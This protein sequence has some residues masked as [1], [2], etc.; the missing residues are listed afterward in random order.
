[1]SDAEAKF[2]ANVRRVRLEKGMT[3]DQVADAAD[4]DAAEI[5]RFESNRRHPGVD[6]IARL[7]NALGVPVCELFEGATKPHRKR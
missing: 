6:V 7:A 4:M 5:R 1:M 2:A 3:Q